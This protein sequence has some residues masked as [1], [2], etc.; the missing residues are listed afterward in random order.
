MSNKKPLH[1]ATVHKNRWLM[2]AIAFVVIVCVGLVG[3]IKVSSESFGYEEVVPS[4]TNNWRLYTN[5][6]HKFSLNLPPQWA[7]GDNNN[8]LVTFA[9]SADADE[10]ISI[11]VK[12]VKSE[13]SVRAAVNIIGEERISINGREALKITNQISKTKIETVVLLKHESNLYVIEGSGKQFLKVLST[14]KIN[15]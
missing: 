11:N 1:L 8:S 10:K 15:S 5:P 2:W 14:F 4:A 9:S 3:Y 6:I 12:D 7:V 13:K